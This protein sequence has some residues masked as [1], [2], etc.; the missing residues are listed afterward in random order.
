MTLVANTDP[1]IPIGKTKDQPQSLRT[2]DHL[3]IRH[4]DPEARKRP[5]GDASVL[6]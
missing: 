6:K 3:T 2:I 1:L 4:K 5:A